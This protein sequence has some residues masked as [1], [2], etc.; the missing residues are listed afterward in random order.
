MAFMALF[1]WIFLLLIPLAYVIVALETVL[2]WV[3]AHLFLVNMIVGALLAV[4]V[5]ILAVLLALRSRW[6]KAG[7]LAWSYIDSVR[8]WKHLEL[9]LVKLLLTLGPVWEG[10]VVLCCILYLIFQPLRFLAPA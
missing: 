2:A 8:G 7:K 6:K 9:I 1:G 10:L 5:L 3:V 4:N